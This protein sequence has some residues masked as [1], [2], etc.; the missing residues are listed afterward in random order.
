MPGPTTR[1]TR[2]TPSSAAAASPL[3]DDTW[4]ATVD[5]RD[6][7]GSQ[8]LALNPDGSFSLSHTYADNLAGDASYT[9]TVTV[10]DDDGGV[11]SDT[12]AATVLNVAPM[13]IL[14]GPTAFTR[15]APPTSTALWSPIPAG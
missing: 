15:V 2:A 5:Y 4:T 8:V 1:S 13:V 10:T 6:G 11:G 14:S 3:V 7:S 9:V 12:V